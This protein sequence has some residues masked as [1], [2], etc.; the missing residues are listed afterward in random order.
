MTSELIERLR[1][2]DWSV[3][4]HNDYRLNGQRMTFWLLTHPSGRWVKGEGPTDEAALAEAEAQALQVP[5]RGEV[6]AAIRDKLHAVIER[7]PNEHM[8][9]SLADAV[10]ALLSVPAM[11]DGWRPIETAPKDGTK[12]DLLYPYPRGRLIDAFWDETLGWARLKPQWFRDKLLPEDEW[13]YETLPNMK[14]L[15]WMPA[16]PQPSASALPVGSTSRLPADSSK[17]D[18]AE[19]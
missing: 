6:E 15:A 13:F 17:S 2:A 10:L 3:A 11:P 8:V 19:G 4:C 14:P 5:A 16:P 18:T 7:R 1:A 9:Q 12:I